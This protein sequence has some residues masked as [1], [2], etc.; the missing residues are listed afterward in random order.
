[1]SKPIDEQPKAGS[2][3]LAGAAMD[4]PLQSAGVGTPDGSG[5]GAVDPASAQN[6]DPAIA[7]L[8]PL[9]PA[10]AAKG[11][12]SPGRAVFLE[13]SL[14]R[15]ILVMTGTG[16]IGLMAIFLGDLA[17][18]FFLGRLGDVEVVA[19]VGY[20][21]SI[22]FLTISIGI[23]LAIAASS[24]VSPALGAGRRVRACSLSTSA[25]VWTFAA[26]AVLALAVYLA[27]S[28]LLTMFGAAGRTHQLAS[29]YLKI[30]VPTLPLLATGMT[31]SAVLRSVGDAR[32]SMYV[33]LAGAI[34]NT[35]LDPVFIF[36]LGLGIEGA[37][38]AS[39]ISRIAIFAI[40]LYGVILVHGLFG[41]P[42]LRQAMRDLAPLGGVAVPAVLT[43]VATPVANA[44][45]TA[46]MSTHGDAAVAGWAI[47]GRII[48]VA[49]G[50]IYALSGSIGPIVGQN[51]GGGRYD[52]MRQG[53]TLSLLVTAAFTGASWLLLALLARPLADLF[54]LTGEAADL[55]ILF[56]RWLAP[57]FVFL[58]WL[59]VANAVFNTLGRAHY[60][61]ML[62]WAR[63]TIGTIPFVM[64][65]GRIWDAPGVLAGNM[66]GGILFG[67]FG[68]LL[69]YRLM[70]WLSEREGANR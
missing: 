10:T 38:I 33:T 29:S 22:Q 35:A 41:Q 42:R 52:R 53:F 65:G 34:V 7:P 9:A 8:A 36:G 50:V 16:A 57:L 25:H 11:N 13:G 69:C 30:I 40:G 32:R 6:P 48:P 23:G 56:C 60:S 45:V 2:T 19:A 68:I 31:S 4:I 59:F 27:V 5:P 1:M 20:A 21:S 47:I 12:R 58:G 66:I 24:L 17:N 63:A 62:N 39:A 49:F 44:Y 64:V 37:A 3:P 55:V 18:I 54:L 61:T 67:V 28:P 43:N 15:H 46:A 26:S 51:F 14:L 70:S